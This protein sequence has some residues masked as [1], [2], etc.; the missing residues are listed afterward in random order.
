MVGDEEAGGTLQ[1]RPAGGAGQTVATVTRAADVLA[2]FCDARRR[3]LGITEIAA[4]LRM[5]KASV[6]RILASLRSRGLVELAPDTHRYSLGPLAMRLGLAYLDALDVRA[7]AAPEL[8]GL[9]Q[10]TGETATLSVR[11]GDAR[12]Y[13]DQVT[14]AREVIMSVTLGAPIPLYLGASSKALLAWL[15]EAADDAALARIIRH[16][17]AI[18]RRRPGSSAAPGMRA[19]G[20]ELADIRA[21]GW[22]RSLGERHPGAGSI[23]APLFDHQN[24]VVAVFSIC[25]PEERF[26]DLDD[27]S[28]RM[29]VAACRRVSARLGHV[30]SCEAVGMFGPRP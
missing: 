30:P 13:V 23:A 29:L 12:V 1:G 9:S 6:H 25:G 4:G 20:G 11:V 2:Y 28:A 16:G 21:R 18:S 22:A 8:R 27:Q 15:P 3:D 10:C 19:L 24:N 7:L 26:R 17:K 5:S 14:P